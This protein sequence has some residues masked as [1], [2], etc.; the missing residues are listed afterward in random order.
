M[1]PP[2]LKEFIMITVVVSINDRRGG[3]G[4][5]EEEAIR[6]GGINAGFNDRRYIERTRRRFSK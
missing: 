5:G 3:G 4:G 1:A 2:L 6:S